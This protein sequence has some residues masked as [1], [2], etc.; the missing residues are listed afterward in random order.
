MVVLTE[1]LY[2]LKRTGNGEGIK[3]GAFYMV[4]EKTEGQIG[5][6]KVRYMN[7]SLVDDVID[8][9]SVINSERGRLFRTSFLESEKVNC[10]LGEEFPSEWTYET[11]DTYGFHNLNNVEE[12]EFR[13]ALV[14]GRVHMRV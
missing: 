12:Y 13:D 8:V 6:K 11:D 4:E 5:I 7:N 9:A 1:G 14:N 10:S 2:V 3:Y